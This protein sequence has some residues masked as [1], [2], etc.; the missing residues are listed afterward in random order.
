MS[1]YLKPFYRMIYDILLHYFII[2]YLKS[3]IFCFPFCFLYDKTSEPSQQKAQEGPMRCNNFLH[4]REVGSA[5]HKCSCYLC[6][7]PA[8]LNDDCLSHNV[9]FVITPNLISIYIYVNFYIVDFDI[10][11]P[12]SV[13]MV[14]L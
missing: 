1:V 14:V 6:F 3:S 13:L 11:F 10:L 4:Q 2:L 7:D 9:V 12:E 8:E 5:G